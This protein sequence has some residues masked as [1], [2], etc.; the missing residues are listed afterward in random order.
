MLPCVIFSR[1]KHVA[2]AKW[3]I[4]NIFRKSLVITKALRWLLFIDIILY[5]Y[6]WSG[7]IRPECRKFSHFYR[8]VHV[9]VNTFF[10][11]FRRPHIRRI[12]AWKEG[13]F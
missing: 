3:L 2:F 7:L 9:N 12:L 1:K 11:A 8:R 10:N 13:D 4:F 5:L 6:I